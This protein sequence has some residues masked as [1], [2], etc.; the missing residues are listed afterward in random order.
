MA[1]SIFV[2]YRRAD[3]AATCGRIYD[4]L[5]DRFGRDA[6]FKDVDSIPAGVDFRTHVSNILDQCALQLV[7]IGAHWLSVTDASGARRLDDPLD[8]VRIEVETALQRNIPVIPLLVDGAAMPAEAGLPPSLRPLAYRNALPVRYDPDFNTDLARVLAAIERLVPA[9][10]APAWIPP[11]APP[12]QLPSLSSEASQWQ[13]QSVPLTAWNATQRDEYV[14]T[15]P[16]FDAMADGV[17]DRFFKTVVVD[18]HR[19]DIQAWSDQGCR[20]VFHDRAEVAR[21]D[22]AV[23]WAPTTFDFTVMEDGAFARYAVVV[24]IKGWFG[25]ATA[26]PE[27]HIKRDGVD[28]Y[29][30]TGDLYLC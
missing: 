2:S 1:A 21:E 7:V 13:Q 6:V 29:S 30:Y 18:G 10:D 3:S 22:G 25:D 17:A 14:A 27:I 9:S 20:R 15:R 8:L 26:T 19:L 16:A 4:R 12:M 24:G 5:A 23:S 11:P 28:T